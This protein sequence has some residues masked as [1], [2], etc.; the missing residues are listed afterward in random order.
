MTTLPEWQP[1]TP[2][3]TSLRL[4]TDRIPAGLSGRVA[5]AYVPWDGGDEWVAG[6][7]VSL[8]RNCSQRDPT[9]LIDGS[10]DRGV[11]DPMARELGRTEGVTDVVLFGASRNRVTHDLGGALT[12]VPAGTAGADAGEVLTSPSWRSLWEGSVSAGLGM[13]IVPVH[14]PG[15][16]AVLEQAQAVIVA[17]TSGALFTFSDSIAAKTVAV[18]GPPGEPREGESV[19]ADP[20]D[21]SDVPLVTETEASLE[22]W[23]EVGWERVGTPEPSAPESGGDPLA[24]ADGE[25]DTG[26]T[27]SSGWS[28]PTKELSAGGV[29]W[30]DL[31]DSFSLKEGFEET[32]GEAS[33]STPPEAP[34]VEVSRLP[35][36]E[37][38]P[39]GEPSTH[40]ARV[41]PEA[42]VDDEDEGVAP[43]DP[44]LKELADRLATS[45]PAPRP[46]PLRKVAFWMLLLLGLFAVWM[47]WIPVLFTRS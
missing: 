25:A 20:V 16:D 3:S 8:A 9:C 21:R 28:E 24:T 30:S 43:R 4:E 10:I 1:L 40:L 18:V 39:T 12:F 38:V 41:D 46:F 34:E 17:Q 13:V 6:F 5:L 15:A 32:P 42:F 33:P 19:V 44:V 22:D 14:Q 45:E 47:G 31:A 29:G 27:L 23:P 7:A 35:G 2:E 11:L 26:S 36:T 37:P